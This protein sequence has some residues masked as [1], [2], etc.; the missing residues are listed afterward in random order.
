M[1]QCAAAARSRN[2]LYMEAL[3]DMTEQGNL[4]RLI[5]AWYTTDRRIAAHLLYRHGTKH[6]LH[7]WKYHQPSVIVLTLAQ[8]GIDHSISTQLCN[9]RFGLL[10]CGKNF[11]RC[12]LTHCMIC[13]CY[14]FHGFSPFRFLQYTLSLL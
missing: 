2:R 11:I 9:G 1:T 12:I 3:T 8:S 5:E 13:K 10:A 4:N 14:I 6:L 7:R